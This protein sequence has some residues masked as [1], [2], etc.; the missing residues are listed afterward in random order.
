MKKRFFTYLL[1]TVSISVLPVSYSY[2][3]TVT[4]SFEKADVNGDNRVD[5]SD[6]VAV[7]NFMAFGSLNDAAVNDGYCPD[8]NHPHVIDMGVAGKWACCN[9]G[10]SA[11]W[12]YGGY[13]S[14]GETK[15]KSTYDWSSYIHCK[16]SYETC[17]DLGSDIAGTDYDVAR[18]QWGVSWNIPS[19]YQ[20]KLL[21]SNCSSKWTEINGING[22]KFTAS[23][24][25]RI[26]LPAA[27]N[28]LNDNKG[29]VG[30]NCYYWSSTQYPSYSYNAYGLHCNSDKTEWYYYTRN[31]GFSVRPVTE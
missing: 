28:R 25:N 1:I 30:S 15:E 19:F 29:F 6:V 2:A 21:L 20:I 8:S 10:A 11:P 31:R 23:N 16:G 22:V 12:E 5:I 26:F 9:V 13:Y 7:I 17:Y 4:V 18:V 3:Q 14:W 27:G 24:G